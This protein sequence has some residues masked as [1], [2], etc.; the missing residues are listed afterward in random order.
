MGDIVPDYDEYDE[1]SEDERPYFPA[2]CYMYWQDGDVVPFVPSKSLG[3]LTSEEAEMVLLGRCMAT[4]GKPWT[5]VYLAAPEEHHVLNKKI[6]EIF[7]RKIRG[8]VVVVARKR[9]YWG[10]FR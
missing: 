1:W 4:R 9:F 5:L 3:L 6:E 2:W 7:H 8:P 10:S